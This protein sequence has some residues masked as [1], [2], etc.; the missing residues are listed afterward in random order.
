MGEVTLKRKGREN[1]QDAGR[2]LLVS[3]LPQSQAAQSPTC[4]ENT[5]RS[6]GGVEGLVLGG[7]PGDR[8]KRCAKKDSRGPSRKAG[9]PL[10]TGLEFLG[11]VRGCSLPESS[12]E[13]MF[14]Y[15]PRY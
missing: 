13:Q 8:E 5:V 1:L 2:I 6:Q 15:L 4:S 3:L 11:Q 10:R 9:A 14:P 12:V 7:G